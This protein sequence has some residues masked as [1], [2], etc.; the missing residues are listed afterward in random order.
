[1]TQEMHDKSTKC[2][3]ALALS[4][5][6][7]LEAGPWGWFGHGREVYLATVHYGRRYVIGFTRSGF[8]GAQPRF[9][10]KGILHKAEEF[11]KF[12]VGPQEVTGLAAARACG[13][14]Y[15]EDV[16]DIAHP[17]AQAIKLIPDMIAEL[18]ANRARIAELERGIHYSS[19]VE[20]L[21][22]SKELI[23]GALAVLSNAMIASNGRSATFEIGNDVDGAFIFRAERRRAA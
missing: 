15:R 23:Q 9:R 18:K 21:M 19:D 5:F 11:L 3:E 4:Q 2:T 12:E 14:V 20:T 13:E 7:G 17:V 1:M 6:D 16:R 10:H 22:P 8:S